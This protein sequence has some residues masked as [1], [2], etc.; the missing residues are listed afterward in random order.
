MTEKGCA[1][2][3][4]SCRY[5]EF[6]QVGMQNIGNKGALEYFGRVST[7][8]LRNARVGHYG[9]NVLDVTCSLKF[10]FIEPCSICI[11]FNELCSMYIL[12]NEQKSGSSKLVH[13][14]SGSLKS[15]HQKSGSLKSVHWKPCS[16]Q[17]PFSQ[18]L[19]C[20]WLVREGCVA[21]AILKWRYLILRNL[22]KSVCLNH[23]FSFPCL[24]LRSIWYVLIC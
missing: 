18:C 12:L 14:E 1:R 9:W 4:W 17:C 5:I 19:I 3:F 10:Q 23:I 16:E 24:R 11:H 15:V 7:Q 20:S 13:L 22:F 21:S 6:G 2:I 8:I